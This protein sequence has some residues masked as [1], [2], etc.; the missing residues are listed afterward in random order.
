MFQDS[1]C[2]RCDKGVSQCTVCSYCCLL[3][4]YPKKAAL[5]R[6]SRNGTDD[7]TSDKGACS[8]AP[9]VS[10]DRRH[11]R[12][13][14]SCRS[15]CRCRSLP[16]PAPP[17]P[18][19]PFAVPPLTVACSPR[20]RSRRPLS[21]AVWRRRRKSRRCRPPP[22][23]PLA[24]VHPMKPEVAEGPRAGHRMSLGGSP[25]R[26]GGPD[27]DSVAGAA[28]TAIVAGL[29]AFPVHPTFLLNGLFWDSIPI[30]Q[31][32]NVSSCAYFSC[33]AGFWGVEVPC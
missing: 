12:Y 17:L 32:R 23:T 24:A 31:K 30:L 9:T 1:S 18:A 25:F 15:S 3:V 5:G 22:P 16:T 14:A 26:V 29:S 27:S 2:C 20:L 33:P 19:S 21:S 4:T 11:L 8:R 13:P 7:R 28:T 10:L 6:R